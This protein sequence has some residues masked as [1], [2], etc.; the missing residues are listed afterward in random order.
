MCIRDRPL[1]AEG[2]VIFVSRSLGI[3]EGTLK[4]AGGNLYAHA[5]ATC[6]ILRPT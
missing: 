2:K 3:S 6:L 5:T 1:I 4:D